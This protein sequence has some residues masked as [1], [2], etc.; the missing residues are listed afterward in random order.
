MNN[1]NCPL[2]KAKR[3]KKKKKKANAIDVSGSKA[4]TKCILQIDDTNKTEN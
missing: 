4:Y 1:N 2:P 3:E